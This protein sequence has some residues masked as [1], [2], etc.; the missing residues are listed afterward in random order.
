LCPTLERPSA[1]RDGLLLRVPLVG[2]AVTAAQLEAVARIAAGFGSGVVELTN[3]ANLQVRGLAEP[4]VAAALDALR[5]VGIP[6]DAGAA[7]VTLS[8][9]A[10]DGDRRL[11]AAI[12]DALAE[13]TPADLSPK[14]R[15]HV[16]DGAG[17][18]GGQRAEAVVRRADGSVRIE[19]PGVGVA[20][21]GTD[22]AVAFLAALAAAC[23]AEGPDARVSDL[24]AAHG[25]DAVTGLGPGAAPSWAAAPPRTNTVPAPR[26]G[27]VAGGDGDGVEVR[28]AA[29]F[30]RVGPTVL[31]GLAAVLDGHPGAEARILADRTV[32][33]RVPAG[34]AAP[35]RGA[36][37]ASL[38]DLGLLVDPGDPAWGVITC[39]GAA[40]CWQTELDTRAEAERAVAERAAGRLA[41]E[42]GAV[43]HVS[44]C[45]KLCA[46][47]APVPVAF[48]G[49]PDSTGFD[50]LHP[51]EPTTA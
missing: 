31:S 36:L 43:I 40:G 10:D 41:T 39:I 48:V 32:G 19:V 23:A 5:A 12:V 26:V 45:D 44:G 27:P 13:A 22:D 16:D 9:S 29:R 6:A 21:A 7:T 1:Q 4:G 42:P 38:A 51:A 20:I 47:R 28:A 25:P 2:G 18:T 37:I 49:R 46:T 35:D 24:L 17:T 11:R 15:I 8:P 50:R 3:R 34:P 30:G 14:F 33:L